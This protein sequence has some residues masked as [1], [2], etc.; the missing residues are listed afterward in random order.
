MCWRREVSTNSI[1]DTQCTGGRKVWPEALKQEIV[2]AA[3]APGASVSVMARQY[4]VNTNLVF[5][6]RRLFSK[7][8]D[9]SPAPQ[10][11]P[12]MVTADQPAAAPA[13]PSADMIEIELPGAV[14]PP[15]QPAKHR[16]IPSGR[17]NREAGS[18]R[19]H[20]A[21]R[22]ATSQVPSPRQTSGESR[23]TPKLCGAT[24]PCRSALFWLPAPRPA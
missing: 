23:L 1:M 22:P 10:F 20:G 4:D 21:I 14:A 8:T 6:W 18:P 11:L 12:I 15:R 13:G 24:C 9:A 3:S 16:D 17:S 5:T 19:R 2:A 7:V